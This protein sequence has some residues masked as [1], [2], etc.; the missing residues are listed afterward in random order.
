MAYPLA[1]GRREGEHLLAAPA[2]L[3][4]A[5]RLDQQVD[6]PGLDPQPGAQ[7]DRVPRVG[8]RSVVQIRAL[9]APCPRLGFEAV[10]LGDRAVGGLA[11]HQGVERARVV[12]APVERQTALEQGAGLGHAVLGAPRG[13]G[14]TLRLGLVVQGVELV[15]DL[16]A[17]PLDDPVEHEEGA[18][19]I[20]GDERLGRAHGTSGE[21]GEALGVVGERR[22]G[23]DCLFEEAAGQF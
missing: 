20:V 16:L 19:L 10:E 12:A 15:V 7:K 4:V 22:V 3:A 8:D 6:R 5:G 14:G 11:A 2:R 18:V 21:L 17:G 1:V 23:V 13:T 9:G